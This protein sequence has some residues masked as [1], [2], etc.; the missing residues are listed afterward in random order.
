MAQAQLQQ[1]VKTGTSLDLIPANPSFYSGFFRIQE[2]WPTFEQDKCLEK[3]AQY[4]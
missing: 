1:P 2:Q 3:T 4:G